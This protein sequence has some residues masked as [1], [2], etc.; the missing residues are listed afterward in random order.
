MAS[1]VQDTR[2][3]LEKSMKSHV[4]HNVS[5]MNNWHRLVVVEHENMSVEAIAALA[6]SN[7]RATAASTVLK[8]LEYSF[9]ADRIESTLFDLIRHELNSDGPKGFLAV[10]VEAQQILLGMDVQPSV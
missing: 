5:L 4:D 9:T 6:S 1:T 10:Y 8:E 3:M 2:V 7:H